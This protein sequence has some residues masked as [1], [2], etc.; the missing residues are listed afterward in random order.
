MPP[1]SEMRLSVCASATAA[2]EMTSKST[3]IPLRMMSS[4]P[5]PIWDREEQ[6]RCLTGE[7]PTFARTDSG[8]VKEREH[9]SGCDNFAGVARKMAHSQKGRRIPDYM[10]AGRIGSV[11]R[12]ASFHAFQPPTSARAF[13]HP[14]LRS[15]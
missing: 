11:G 12:P 5:R 8:D 9:D 7:D 10:P 2:V 1:P 4:H 13:G 6:R 15:W 3:K 14:A